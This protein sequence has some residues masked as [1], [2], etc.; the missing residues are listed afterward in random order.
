MRRF[1][2]HFT[3]RPPGNEAECG[4]LGA[5]AL[6]GGALPQSAVQSQERDPEAG[7]PASGLAAWLAAALRWTRRGRTT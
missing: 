2:A 3:R 4:W 1:K 7:A 5:E 6:P